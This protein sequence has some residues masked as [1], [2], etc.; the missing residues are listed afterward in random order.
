M[1]GEQFR[2]V[3]SSI[4]QVELNSIRFAENF[5][6]AVDRM[7]SVSPTLVPAP[8]EIDPLQFLLKA[9]DRFKQIEET[10][11]T[12]DDTSIVPELMPDAAQFNL[13][14]NAMLRA[15]AETLGPDLD[16][17]TRDAWIAALHGI[18][19]RKPANRTPSRINERA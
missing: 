14:A 10:T 12:T 16:P 17:G 19:G 3:E 15:L 6:S 1:S 8:L 13:A 11:E 9:R 2:L 5:V 7:S 18:A 4:G